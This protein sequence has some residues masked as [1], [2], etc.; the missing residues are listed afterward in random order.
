LLEAQLIA[1]HIASQDRSSVQAPVYQLYRAG[2]SGEAAAQ[3]L[4]AALQE[5][6]QA[7]R[8]VVIPAAAPAVA[9]RQ[10]LQSVRDAGALVLWLRPA[11]LQALGELAAPS[12]PV[13]LSGLMGGLEQ[14]PLPA[15]WRAHAWLSY[16]FDLPDRRLVRLEYPLSWFRIRHIP[17]V[18]EQVQVDTYLACGLLSETLNHMSDNFGREYLVERV[19]EMLGHRILTGYYPRLSLAE[20]QRFA[21]KGGY[22]VQLPASSSGTL[23]PDGGWVVP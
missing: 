7:S 21:S 16:P 12:Q 19:E 13:F 2:D 6:G 22:L 8:N 11:D 20:G 23:N 9:V 17:V 3:A 14:A 4:T 10:A 1:R 15:E 5:S 18:A